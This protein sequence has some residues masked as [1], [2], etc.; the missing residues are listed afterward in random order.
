MNK[1]MSKRLRE[2]K[3]HSGD[4]L[5]FS[6]FQLILT[7]AIVLFNQRAA[8]GYLIISVSFSSLKK[9]NLAKFLTKRERK[10]EWKDLFLIESF[11]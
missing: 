9:D 8:D 2:K 10:R 4:F 5:S 7:M 6:F 11:K 1:K 3:I